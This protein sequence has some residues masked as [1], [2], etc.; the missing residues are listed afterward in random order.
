MSYKELEPIT[1]YGIILFSISTDLPNNI[2]TGIEKKKCADLEN[3][4]KKYL[5]FLVYQRRDSYEYMDLIKG[6]YA[7]ENKFKELVSCLCTEEKQRL[8]DYT[9]RQ[10][11]DDL[12]V[13]HTSR[14]YHQGYETARK[15]FER[16]KNH[17]KTAPISSKMAVEPPW[18]FP[19]GRKFYNKRENNIECALREFAEETGLSTSS[20]EILDT[21]PFVETYKGDNDKSYRTEYFVAKCDVALKIQKIQT[22]QCIRDITVSEEAS[23]V[24]WV[25]VPE[26]CLKLEPRRQI[27]LKGVVHLIDKYIC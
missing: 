24:K 9:F 10:L 1:S 8:L 20:V 6:A 4:D 22:P 25:S 15:K 26:A 19:K 17:I 16:Y 3:V 7:T 12:W 21:K 27:I 5:L 11:W 13:S 2:D 14:T 18:G 23:E